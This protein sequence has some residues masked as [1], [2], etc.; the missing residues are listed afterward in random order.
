[1]GIKLLNRFLLERC[2]KGS[3][4]KTH[5]QS[6]SGKK[7]VIDTSIYLYKFAAENA[8]AENMYL[9]ISI[10]KK[11][12]IEP[13]FIFD[14]KP[15]DEKKE[16]LLQRRNDKKEAQQKYIDIKRILDSEELDE[17][18]RNAMLSNMEALKKQFIRI[19]DVDIVKMKKLMDAYGVCYYDAPGEADV[20]CCRFVKLGLAWACLSDDMDMFVYGCTRVLRHL[21]ILNHTVIFYNTENILHD[22]KLS[23]DNLSDILVLSGTDYNSRNETNLI[24]TLKWHNEYK[25][26]SNWQSMHFYDWLVKYTK[27]IKD[28]NRLLSA[29]SMFVLEN[30]EDVIFEENAKRPDIDKLKTLLMEDGF[31]FV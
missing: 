13:I 17:E 16:L 14:G 23:Q 15:P 8:I 10:F 9:M 30:N 29:R 5:L 6:L 25:K 28:I 22:I 11:Y 31:V 12:K 26:S 4:Y 27:Y 21:S 2:N 7:V 19:K 1:M 20:L 24:E 18:K 3:I